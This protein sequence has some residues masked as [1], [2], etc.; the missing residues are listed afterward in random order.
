MDTWNEWQDANG[1]WY[2]NPDEDFLKRLYP[3]L[4]YDNAWDRYNDEHVRGPKIFFR[5][6]RGGIDD[7]DMAY[8]YEITGIKDPWE[9]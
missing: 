9:L 1:D 7:L 6:K 5:G 2:D 4:D 3:D 8:Y